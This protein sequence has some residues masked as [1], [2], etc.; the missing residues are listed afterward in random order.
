MPKPIDFDLLSSWDLIQTDGTSNELSLPSLPLPVD[1]GYGPLR[2]AKNQ[3]GRRQLLVPVDLRYRLPK[4]IGTECI[5]VQIQSLFVGEKLQ[6][7]VVVTCLRAELDVVFIS[8][9]REIISRLAVGTPTIDSIETVIEEYRD[10]L[11][12]PRELLTT[13]Q[14]IGLFGE[15][16]ILERLLERRGT[17]ALWTGPF[18]ARHDFT[19]KSNALEV[20]STIRRSM[21]VI[22]VT[23]IEQLMP[24][25]NGGPLFL[26][27]VVLERS[28]TGGR[29]IAELLDTVSALTDDSNRL[30]DALAHHGL[31]AWRTADDLNDQKF[32]VVFESMYRVDEH[33]PSLSLDSMKS[34]AV[35]NGILDITYSVDLT[36]ASRCLLND[37]ESRSVIESLAQ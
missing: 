9:A 26:S 13:E 22:H 30:A 8:V 14:L 21:P 31:D 17:S 25:T 27:H 11:R 18:G 37:E 20:K 19:G 16:V 35:P 24:P 32:N 1:I 7:F 12:Q 3:T 23:S 33:F 34:G 5:A 29:S 28:G 2:L 4:E 15:L 6:R 36:F 10:L